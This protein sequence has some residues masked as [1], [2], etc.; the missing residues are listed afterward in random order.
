M[1]T[2]CVPTKNRPHFVE[3]LLAWYVTAGWTSPILLGD[4]SEE[5]IADAVERIVH[6]FRCATYVRMP[7]TNVLQT[8]HL[9]SLRITTP[10]AAWVSDDDYLMPAGLYDCQRF[11]EQHPDIVACHGTGVIQRRDADS[12]WGHVVTQHP[13]VALDLMEDTPYA[14]LAQALRMPAS[15]HTAL[16]RTAD[17]AALFARGGDLPGATQGMIF[18]DL[19]PYCLAAVQGKTKR[20]DTPYLIRQSHDGIYRQCSFLD[21]LTHPDWPSMYGVLE[22]ALSATIPP[23][24]FRLLFQEYLRQQFRA[25]LTN[26]SSRNVFQ[27]IR[28]SWNRWNAPAAL[29]FGQHEPMGAAFLK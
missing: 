19:I 16:R 28:N 20:L 13:Y 14:R 24:S 22:T 18:D 15:L 7:Q 8:L 3:R 5:Q 25:T 6:A 11:L 29:P 17:F 21:W 2:L 9:L 4:A 23:A 1:M 10:Y 12:P 26:R 27:W